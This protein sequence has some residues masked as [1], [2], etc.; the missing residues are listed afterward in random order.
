VVYI[1]KFLKGKGFLNGEG[2]N[3]F[4]RGREKTDLS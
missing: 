4:F 1:I 3:G 2:R